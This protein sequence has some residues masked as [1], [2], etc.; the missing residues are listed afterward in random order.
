MALARP[1]AY[2]G[3]RPSHSTLSPDLT[4]YIIMCLVGANVQMWDHHGRANQRFDINN[5]GG[6]LYSFRSRS[7]GGAQ[8]LDVGG[9]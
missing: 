3:T 8:A 2:N 1:I 5:H 7:T 6:N 4:V 9:W